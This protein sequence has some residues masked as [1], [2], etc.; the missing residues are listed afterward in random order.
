MHVLIAYMKTFCAKRTPAQASLNKRPGTPL[1]LGSPAVTVWTNPLFM[2]GMVHK[3][4]RPKG[5]KLINLKID[6]NKFT[7]DN[8]E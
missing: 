2:I 8:I 4:G 3:Y 7:K 1:A 5:P 6:I